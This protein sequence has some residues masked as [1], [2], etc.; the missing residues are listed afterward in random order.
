MADDAGMGSVG[1]GTGPALATEI[2]AAFEAI[3]TEIERLRTLDLGET[4]PAV[5]FHPVPARRP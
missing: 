1:G 3:R 5:I 4:H 2:A